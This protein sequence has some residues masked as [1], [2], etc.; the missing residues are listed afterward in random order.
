MSFR[1]RL[2]A[3]PYFVA[4]AVAVGMLALVQSR[5]RGPMRQSLMG[6]LGSV[7]TVLTTTGLVFVAGDETT[8]V[9]LVRFSQSMAVWIAPVALE[10]AHALTGRPLRLLRR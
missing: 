4:A 10:F 6:M 2:W 5:G 1:W 8:A 7:G 9:W 3:L